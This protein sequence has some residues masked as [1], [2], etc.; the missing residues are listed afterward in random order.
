MHLGLLWIIGDIW[1]SSG[2]HGHPLLEKV[3]QDRLIVF[4][5]V[6]DPAMD[7]LKGATGF[8]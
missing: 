7:S 3:A 4:G 5:A 8:G 1:R 6:T 2:E